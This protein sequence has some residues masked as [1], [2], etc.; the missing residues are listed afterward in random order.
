MN[1]KLV[2]NIAII[3]VWVSFVIT[4]GLVFY[5][6]HYMPHGPSY[7]TGE[8]VCEN[9]DRGPC[10]PEYKEDTQNL[11]I[12]NWAI[13]IKNSEGQLLWMGLLFLGVILPTFK[14]KKTEE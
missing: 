8:Y 3:I 6:N 2:L 1:K 7:A 11:N 13:F 5:V 12:P 10:G 4:S 14:N 9:D